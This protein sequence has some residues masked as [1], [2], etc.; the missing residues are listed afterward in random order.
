[1]AI[2]GEKIVMPGK[3][4]GYDHR[5]RPI[6]GDPVEFQAVVVPEGT[7][8]TPG[9][10]GAISI[11][12]AGMKLLIPNGWEVPEGLEVGAQL[13]VREETYY[14]DGNLIEHRSPFGTSRG[15]IEVKLTTSYVAG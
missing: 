7:E 5:G 14:M 12:S 10:N 9:S 2:V 3:P 15:G 1:M 11:V 13:I 8:L 4:K 6:Y